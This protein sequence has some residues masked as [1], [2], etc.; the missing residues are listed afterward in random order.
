MAQLSLEQQVALLA[1][2]ERTIEEIDARKITGTSFPGDQ[3]KRGSLVQRN[4]GLKHS[5]EEQE[6]Q[7]AQQR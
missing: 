4:L 5:I 6:A 7:M 3:K 1:I 2:N